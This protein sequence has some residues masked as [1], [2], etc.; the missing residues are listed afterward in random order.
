MIMVQYLFCV[1]K[2]V[3]NEFLLKFIYEKR[4]ITHEMA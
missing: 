1:S 2:C 4:D 3:R